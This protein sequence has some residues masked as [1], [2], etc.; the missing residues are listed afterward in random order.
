MQILFQ[1]FFLFISAIE[2]FLFFFA[3]ACFGEHENFKLKSIR[4][5][6]FSQS[7][8][9]TLSNVALNEGKNGDFSQLLL[10]SCLVRKSL[11]C[12]SN[13]VGPNAQET[14]LMGH[15]FR[16]GDNNHSQLQQ[17]TLCCLLYLFI[18]LIESIHCNNTRIINTH[19]ASFVHGEKMGKKI[20]K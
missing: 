7:F 3:F 2:T 12:E 4:F 10:G 19:F 16:K 14:K 11:R 13:R 15:I 8:Y 20:K 6:F 18:C 5:T 17:Q 1:F 9:L